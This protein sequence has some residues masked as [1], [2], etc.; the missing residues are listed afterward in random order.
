LYVA[1]SRDAMVSETSVRELYQRAPEPK[2]FV[3]VDSDH[4]Y[5][6]ERARTAVLEWLNRLHPRL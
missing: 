3:S 1:A 6:G 2:T 5:A 4:T